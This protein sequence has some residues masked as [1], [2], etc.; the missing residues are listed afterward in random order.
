MALRS[1]TIQLEFGDVLFHL[2]TVPGDGKKPQA[3]VEIKLG[4]YFCK[5]EGPQSLK[6]SFEHK[7][8]QV[9]SQDRKV[10]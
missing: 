9:I 2:H 5:L 4:P 7:T 8:H 1:E 10:G 3:L 6:R